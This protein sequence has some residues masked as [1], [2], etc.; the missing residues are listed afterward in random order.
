MHDQWP[1]LNNYKG[2]RV[3]TQKKSLG[4]VIVHISMAVQKGL[5]SMPYNKCCYKKNSAVT[6]S[7]KATL[8]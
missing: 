5:Y 3:H 8:L 1:C 2:D 6:K 4:E 7:V